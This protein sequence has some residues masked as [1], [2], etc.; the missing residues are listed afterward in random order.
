MTG[1]AA[2][3]PWKSPLA[4]AV[5]MSLVMLVAV[6]GWLLTDPNTSRSD[7]LKTGGLAGAAVVALYGLWLNDRRRRVEEGRQEIERQRH[8]LEM[9]RTEQDRD[10]ISDERFAKAV[11]LLGNNADQVRVGAMHALA[12]VARSR[13]EYTQTVLD[14]LCSYLRRP[15]DHV[16]YTQKDIAG[17]TRDVL[18]GDGEHDLGDQ[19]R[20]LQVRLTA[21]RLILDLLPAAKDGDA[22][23]YDLDLTGAVLEYFDLSGRKIG[24]LL[25]RHTGLH[26]STNLS[27]CEITGRAYFT[28]AGTGPGRLIGVFRCRETTFHDR[29]WFSGTHFGADAVFDGTTFAGETTFKN[30]VFTADASLRDVSFGGSLD[31][32][33]THFDGHTDLSFATPPK[34]VALYNTIVN[35]DRD[36]QLPV[37]WELETISSGRTRLTTPIR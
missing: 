34:S 24:S 10:R 31:L 27:A 36:L 32:H 35:P 30:A 15:F 9:R 5:A 2:V 6:G 16:R 17:E 3:K 1:P 26:S 33:Q 11:E 29:A 19:E 18:P 28:A 20:E 13:K 14:V 25:M 4:G 22:P 8:E 37:G 23:S 21:Q 12:G 7:A